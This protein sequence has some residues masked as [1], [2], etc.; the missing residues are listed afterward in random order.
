MEPAKLL[1]LACVRLDLGLGIAALKGQH[2]LDVFGTGEFTGQRE[3]G[4]C[5][6]LGK[7]DR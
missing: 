3:A 2:A 6:L 5:V 1:G 4:L 7:P